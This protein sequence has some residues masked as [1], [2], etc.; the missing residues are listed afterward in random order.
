MRIYLAATAPGSEGK[1]KI[2]D[3]PRRLLSYHHIITN[4]LQCNEVFELIMGVKN[5]RQSSEV[6]V[7]PPRRKAG[8]G[9]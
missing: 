8:T 4:Q 3:V 2:L 7:R 9:E 1:G 6:A 5:E